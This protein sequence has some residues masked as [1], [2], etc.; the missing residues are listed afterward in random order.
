[1][2]DPLR[3]RII[4]AVIAHMAII[5]IGNGY[6]TDCGEHV[7]RARLKIEP[8]DCPAIVVWP[9]PEE[10][11][12]QYGKLRCTMPLK[13]EGFVAYGDINPSIIC[14]RILADL[15]EAMTGPTW[16]LPFTSGS[17]APAAGEMVTGHTSGATGF[18]Q[19]VTVVSGSWAEGDAAGILTLRRVFG[20]FI[21]EDL[22]IGAEP[23][24]ASIA[25]APPA[26]LPTALVT[27]GLAESIDYIGGGTD[28]YPDAGEKTAGCSV[29]FNVVYERQAGNPYA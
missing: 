8:A 21:A 26:A 25:G 17:R 27:G 13:L 23:D 14:E 5:R 18:V 9:L 7:F 28:T 1:M 3:E 22:D 29:Q 4:Q 19:A 11:V 24:V 16:S 6:K 15:I 12:K 20:T 2:S 10:A